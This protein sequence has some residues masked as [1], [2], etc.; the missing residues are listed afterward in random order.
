MKEVRQEL[1]EQDQVR[2]KYWSVQFSCRAEIALA[3][4]G[5]NAVLP[6]RLLIIVG[7]PVCDTGRLH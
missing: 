1:R 7:A 5:C 4:I 2:L 3:L 6:G